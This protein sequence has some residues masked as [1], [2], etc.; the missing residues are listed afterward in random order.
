MPG[1]GGRVLCTGTTVVIQHHHIANPGDISSRHSGETPAIQTGADITLLVNWLVDIRWVHLPARSSL[2]T[3][4]R[5]QASSIDRD[6]LDPAYSGKR[7]RQTLLLEQPRRPGL[8]I[9]AFI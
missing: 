8:N 5:I 6:Q 3:N 7:I 9:I 2:S 1:A 4:S